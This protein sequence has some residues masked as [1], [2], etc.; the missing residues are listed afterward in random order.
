MIQNTRLRLEYDERTIAAII[1]PDNA[2]YEFEDL[3]D[4]NGKLIPGVWDDFKVIEDKLDYYDLEDATANIGV[5]VQQIS[6]GRYFKGRLTRV[7]ADDTR[8]DLCLIQVFPEEE[9]VTVY[10]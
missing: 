9:L 4:G 6:T 10:K 7:Y 2:V 8:Y 5:Y 3:N 1:D